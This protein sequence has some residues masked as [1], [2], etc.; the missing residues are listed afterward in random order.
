MTNTI[1]TPVIHAVTEKQVFENVDIILEKGL[2]HIFLIT[3]GR[4]TDEQLLQCGYK[5]K[6]QHL[7]LWTGIN[8]LGMSTAEALAREDLIP[9]DALWCDGSISQTEAKDVRV[10]E[11]LFFGGLAF[12]YQP[13]TTDLYTECYNAVCSTDVATTSG[14]GTGIAADDEKIETILKYLNGHPLAIASGVSPENIHRYSGKIDYLLVASSITEKNEIINPD[15]L[16]QLID[17]L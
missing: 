14:V 17:N 1:I 6:E 9:F 13:K 11:G 15:K 10:F 5:V 2:N 3:H 8:F 7:D 4:M 16:Q 12:K